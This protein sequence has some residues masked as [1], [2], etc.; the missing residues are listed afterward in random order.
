MTSCRIWDCASTPT[1]LQHLA[2]DGKNEFQE[3][4]I[5]SLLRNRRL[6]KFR[7]WDKKMLCDTSQLPFSM[8]II[9][10]FNAL[11]FIIWVNTF[12]SLIT[13]QV[14]IVLWSVEYPIFK[15]QMMEGDKFRWTTKFHSPRMLSIIYKFS[16][17]TASII[18]CIPFFIFVCI[19]LLSLS[20]VLF[21]R[22]E[23][24]LSCIAV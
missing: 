21:N 14:Y 17:I 7:N 10:G 3:H 2:C 19:L 1:A 16:L 24:K 13:S 18:I 20:I 23:V 15:Y 12:P 11:Y 9:T 4:D 8:S 5:R 22:N 6:G